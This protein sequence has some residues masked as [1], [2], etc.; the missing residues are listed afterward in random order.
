MYKYLILM[1]LCC[2]A[3]AASACHKSKREPS[4]TVASAPA[5][6]VSEDA[7]YKPAPSPTEDELRK[8]IKRNYE[9]VVMVDQ[10]RR[11]PFLT[12]DFN[13]D[14][15]PDIAIIVRPGTGKLPDLNSEYVNWILED[16]HQIPSGSRLA[17]HT[18]AASIAVGL[19]DVL[20]AVI[21]GH[22]RDGWRNPLARQTY[23]LK[24]AV[25]ADFETQSPD[26]LRTT[27]ENRSLPP[28]RGDVIREKLAGASGIIY[29]TGARYAWHPIS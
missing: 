5:Q 6:A 17:A 19:N 18:R 21:H 7:G 28:L 12:G 1:M 22:E 15:S 3:I 4:A 9:D 29:W 13:G 14:N 16:L 26:Q 27:G 11:V 10:S 2:A 8:V 24:N 23:L 20:L 25:G